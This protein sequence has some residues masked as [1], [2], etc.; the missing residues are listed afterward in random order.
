ME[1][2]GLCAT[3]QSLFPAAK[4]PPKPSF[5]SMAPRDM[6]NHAAQ[7]ATVLKDIIN[8]QKLSVKIGPT[9]Y[10]KAEGWATLGAFLGILPREREVIERENGD[11]EAYV[12]LVRQSDGVVVGGASA[13]CGHDEKRWAQADRYARR[14]MATT[15]ATGKSYRLSFAWIVTLAGYAPTPYEEMPAEVVKEGAREDARKAKQEAKRGPVQPVHE[16]TE[17]AGY[18]PQ[19]RT[20]QDWLMKQL[21]AKKYPEE[22]WDDIGKALKGR[23]ASDFER[24][25]K[26][27]AVQ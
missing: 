15:R 4:S 6:A 13:L 20:H 25:L 5:F 3:E 1:T 18:D 2:T 24:V 9:E 11:F 17:D 16:A 12:D 22:K 27:H 23:P 10:V 8:K 19:N 21:K 26:E 7:I 14:S